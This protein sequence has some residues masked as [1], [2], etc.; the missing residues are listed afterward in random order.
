MK[1]ST[2]ERRTTSSPWRVLVPAALVVIAL[3]M[4]PTESPA[5]QLQPDSTQAQPETPEQLQQLVAPIALYPDA[6][7]A[8]ILAAATY[9]TEV[10]QADR[11]VQQHSNLSGAELAAVVDQQ[12]WDPSLK[13]LAAFPSVLANMDQNLSW[14][15]A[16]GDAYFNQPHDVLDAVQVMRRRAE[17]A[18]NLQSTLQEQ[19]VTEG[20]A[21][22]IEPAYP[23]VCY[24][25][26]YDPWIV[27]GAPL[28]PF[29]GYFYDRWYGPPEVTFGPAISLGFVGRFGWG[30]PAWGF[31]WPSRVVV[32]NR[33]PY[34]TRSRFFFH[35][36]P[37]FGVRAGFG[38]RPFV[39]APR[40]IPPRV[41][42]NIAPRP[43]A[44]TPYRYA[45]PN[46]TFNRNAPYG[47]FAP[48]SERP[49]SVA[50]GVVNRGP[51]VRGGTGF[52][53]PSPGAARS[54]GSRGG[55]RHP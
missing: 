3:T 35:G 27:Y 6:L 54:I 32:F 41:G 34:V 53:R 30:W 47:N 12:S 45:V 1:V 18:G 17:D 19:T 36:G 9:P 26:E 43:H 25:P 11:W 15:E 33:Y 42:G 28:A 4:V 5:Q 14:T 21:I 51:I 8:Q 16:L 40:V 48:R 52:S 29:P 38:A 44:T 22:V 55:G 49:A 23:D 37:A 2:I 50:P 10:V 7:V 39:P 13:A 24:V 31:N 46:R 20:T